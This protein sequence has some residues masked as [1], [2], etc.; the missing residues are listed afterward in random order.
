M[1]GSDTCYEEIRKLPY[2]ICK[3]LVLDRDQERPKNVPFEER[4]E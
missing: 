3:S 2:P 1:K 4:S